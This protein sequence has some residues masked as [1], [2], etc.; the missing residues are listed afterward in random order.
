[1][2]DVHNHILP[3]I[4]D[5][6]ENIEESL[7]LLKEAQNAGFDKI[8]LTPHYKE[9]VFEIEVDEKQELFFD[10]FK[11][12][13][14][15]VP[16]V[17]IYLGNEIMATGNIVEYLEDNKAS[18]ISGTRYLL[19]E[20]PLSSKPV[21]FSD[22]VYEM[23]SKKIIPI[24]AHPERY[25]YVQ[26]NPEVIYDWIDMGVLMQQNFGSIIGQYGKSAQIIAKKMLETDSVHF[27]GT[28][29][30]R[31]NTVY[32]NMPKILERLREIIDQDVLEE[33][34]VINP[35][36]VLANEKFD[37]NTPDKIKLNFFEKLK[38]K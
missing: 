25:L 10:F 13:K 27:L 31:T 33:L 30:H 21:K 32:S 36:H 16:Q 20:I 19:F 38:M 28:D 24:L 1:M 2:I 14:N 15:R 4:D 18:T 29:V 6:A 17:D 23:R 3:G 7:E 34:T 22:I 37:I 8:I 35:M 5:G 9:G 11:I 12:A 26:E